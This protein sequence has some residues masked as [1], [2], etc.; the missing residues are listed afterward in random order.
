MA[1]TPSDAK[2]IELVQTVKHDHLI[3]LEKKYQ[4][5]WAQEKVFEV[6]TPDPTDVTG[7]SPPQ[8]HEKHPKWFGMFPYPY[9]N[10]WGTRSL[11]LLYPC[12]FADILQHPPI[13]DHRVIG[14]S[15]VTWVFTQ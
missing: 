9:M 10:I 5:F 2:P 7:L 15:S 3:A 11:S 6:N 8:M 13:S 1:T 14:H 4:V 12:T